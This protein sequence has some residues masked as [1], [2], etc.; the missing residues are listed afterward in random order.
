[1]NQLKA[2]GSGKLPSQ[3]LVNP[4]ENV[5]AV[6][7]RSGKQLEES[8]DTS[9]KNKENVGESDHIFGEVE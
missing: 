2:Q 1:M 7:L 9:K 8:V 4:K 3:P 5:C 6:T